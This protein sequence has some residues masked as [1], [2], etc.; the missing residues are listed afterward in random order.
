MLYHTSID[1]ML[2]TNFAL[3]QHHNWSLIDIE[4]MLPWERDVYVNY[5]IKYLEKQKLEA[6]QAEA[7]NANTW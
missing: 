7:A 2:E 3:I 4:N 6:K 1:A 5:L